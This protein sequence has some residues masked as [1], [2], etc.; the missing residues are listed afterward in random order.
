MTNEAKVGVLV[1]AAVA[2]FVTTFL[3]VATIQLGGEKIEYRTYFKFAGGVETG[4]LVRYGGRKAGVVR[5]IAP[6]EDDPTTTEIVFEMRD[7]VPVNEKSVAKIS[8]LSALGDNYIEVTPGDKDAA[9][10]PPGGVVPSEEAIS[11]SDITA[12]VAEVTDNANLVITDLKDDLS[13]LIGD[14]REL[15]SNLHELTGEENQENV[16]S[17]LANANQLVE[18]QG[19][20]FD[21]I[22]TQ[23][24]EVLERVD[25]TVADMRKVAQTADETVANVNRTVEETRE[26]I[27]RDIE[28]LEATLVEA[29]EMLEEIRAI[30]AVNSV[31]LNDTIENFRVTSEN[32]E[33]FTDEIRQRPF[34]L[35]RAK[36]KPERQVPPTS[37]P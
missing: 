7:D 32:L 5:R 1:I 13:L 33:Q 36:P 2:I 10:I 12:K 11:F 20:K 24:S 27:K 17:M 14:L 30:V 21:R 25:A 22:T 26:P 9:R 28:E 4:D 37:A 6:A 29:R 34:S 8:S 31:N 19:P 15:T 23:I 18:D 16:R 3:S 35:L